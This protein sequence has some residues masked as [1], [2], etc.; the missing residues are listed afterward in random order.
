[1]L[2]DAVAR[3]YGTQEGCATRP[4]FGVL[5]TKVAH[6]CVVHKR[7]DDVDVVSRRCAQEG[8]AGRPTYGVLGTRAALY[9]AVHKS[10]GDVNVRG[11]GR[12]RLAQ[13][14]GGT[15]KRGMAVTSFENNITRPSK[16]RRLE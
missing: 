12:P 15:Q 7:A 8:C 13:V 16:R 14:S 6:Y 4:V 3:R 11:G 5:G 2:W 1:M 9:C 10:P